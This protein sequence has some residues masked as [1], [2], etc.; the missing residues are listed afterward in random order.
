MMLYEVVYYLRDAYSQALGL[1][2]EAEDT[3]VPRWAK[4][5]F[6]P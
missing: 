3:G 1:L 6:D 5:V 2:A 4:A